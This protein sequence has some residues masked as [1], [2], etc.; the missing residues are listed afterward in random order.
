MHDSDFASGERRVAVIF[1]WDSG[2]RDS[3]FTSGKAASCED[4]GRKL[5]K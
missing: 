1:L 4:W 2:A 3:N 5:E